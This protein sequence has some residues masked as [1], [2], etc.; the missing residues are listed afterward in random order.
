MAGILHHEEH[1]GHE[2]ECRG[3]FERFVCFVVR[4]IC[5]IHH[6][7]H[8]GHEVECRGAFVRFVCFVVSVAG[9]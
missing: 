9:S 6:E 4:P 7:G 2:E 5:V 3:D 1:E 8:E